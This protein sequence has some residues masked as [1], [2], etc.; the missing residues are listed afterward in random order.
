MVV[1]RKVLVVAYRLV[2]DDYFLWDGVRVGVC[3]SRAFFI[4]RTSS[5][6]LFS[7]ARWSGLERSFGGG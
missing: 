1:V 7:W 2:G 3:A 4:F 5:V 6:G